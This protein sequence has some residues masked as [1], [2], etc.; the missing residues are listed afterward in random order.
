MEARAGCQIEPADPVRLFI[1]GQVN[2]YATGFRLG[3]ANLRR[4]DRDRVNP[5]A[6]DPH[7]PEISARV[8]RQPHP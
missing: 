4:S 8:P 7:R 1:D 5:P 2:G 3:L 6:A